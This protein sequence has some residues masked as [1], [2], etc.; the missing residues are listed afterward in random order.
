MDYRDQVDNLTWERDTKME[1]ISIVLAEGIKSDKVDYTTA[2]SFLFQ[3]ADFV[4]QHDDSE[5]KAVQKAITKFVT[6]GTI[7][8]GF[9]KHPFIT[10]L[11]QKKQG[12][13]E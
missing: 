8:E 4:Y 6:H 1:D 5:R 3:I 2:R 9:E 12:T 10:A 7:D 13:K 11:V